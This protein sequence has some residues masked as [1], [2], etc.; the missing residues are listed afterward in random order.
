MRNVPRLL[1]GGVLITF[2]LGAVVLA[3]CRA[4]ADEANNREHTS[5]ASMMMGQPVFALACYGQRLDGLTGTSFTHFDFTNHNDAGA[6]TISRVVVYRSDGSLACEDT[7]PKVL[8]PHAGSHLNSN[9]MA[10]Q[11]CPTWLPEP[12]PG[13]HA[14]SLIAYWSP[15]PGVYGPFNPLSGVSDITVTRALDGQV[16]RTAFECKAVWSR[17]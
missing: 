2:A 12:T 5:A 9:Q 6:I 3:G 7:Q 14:F 13:T 4:V 17:N 11:L 16:L 1:Q 10:Q 8:G 15:S